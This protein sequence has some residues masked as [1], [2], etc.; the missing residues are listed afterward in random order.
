MSLFTGSAT[1]S[2]AYAGA[3]FTFSLLDAMNG[4]EGVVECAFV[5]SEETECKYFSTPL[6]LGVSSFRFS[7]VGLRNNWNHKLLTNGWKINLP[8]FTLPT[9]TWL[10]ILDNCLFMIFLRKMA[11]IRTLALARSQPLRRSWL[12][13]PWMNLRAPSRKEK[14]LLQRWSDLFLHYCLWKIIYL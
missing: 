14:T 8:Y 12:L 7:V 5:R 4:K 2:M 10:F 13:K 9:K 6:L 3:R 11:L 1:L